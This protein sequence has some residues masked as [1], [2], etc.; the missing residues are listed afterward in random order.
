MMSMFSQTKVIITESFNIDKL[1]DYELEYF[2]KYLHN[3]NK[4]SYLLLLTSKVDTRKKGYKLLKEYFTII[5][6]N[7]FNPNDVS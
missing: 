1:T 3:P 5:D 7:D 2:N 6:D 4:D